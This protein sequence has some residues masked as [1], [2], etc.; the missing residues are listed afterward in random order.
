MAGGRYDGLVA[1][2]GGPQTPAVG[3]AAGVERLAMLLTDFPAP[4]RPVA[5]IPLGEAAE[6][7]PC[8]CCNRC[9]APASAPKWPIAAT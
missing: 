5:I 9:A 6:P 4:P 2:M 8:R 3:W 7:P 1:E